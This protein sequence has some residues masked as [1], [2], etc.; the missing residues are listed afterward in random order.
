[1]PK[2]CNIAMGRGFEHWPG[3][4]LLFVKNPQRHLLPNQQ[5][6]LVH[7]YACTHLMLPLCHRH[8]VILHDVDAVRLELPIQELDVWSKR[9]VL[10]SE[11]ES[12]S[13]KFTNLHNRME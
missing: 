3:E 9:V 8:L 4:I 7:N 6:F 2:V 1:M 11:L 13:N 12:V 10:D 5:P